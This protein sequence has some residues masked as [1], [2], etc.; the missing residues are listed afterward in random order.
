MMHATMW[1]MHAMYCSAILHTNEGQFDHVFMAGAETF[2][3]HCIDFMNGMS[4]HTKWIRGSAPY[5]EP[6]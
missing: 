5:T 3:S 4:W 6:Q 2:T 1:Q